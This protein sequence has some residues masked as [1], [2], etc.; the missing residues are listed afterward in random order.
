MICSRNYK[1]SFGRSARQIVAIG[2]LNGNKVV[3][4]SVNE[5]YRNFALAQCVNGGIARL[6]LLVFALVYSGGKPFVNVVV[7]VK[8]VVYYVIPYFIRGCKCAVGYDSV[9]AFW[10]LK[11][12]CH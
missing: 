12:A 8:I 10:K 1:K 5:Q 4:R 3:V 2:H 9:N 11:S 7:D 6:G